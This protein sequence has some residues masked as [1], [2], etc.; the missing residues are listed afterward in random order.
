VNVIRELVF[1]AALPFVLLGVVAWGVIAR[2][3]K[4][5][6]AERKM[7]VGRVAATG[8]KWTILLANVLLKK[9]V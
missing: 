5:D 7:V 8:I 9:C 6:E 4:K 3:G 1:V 2:V